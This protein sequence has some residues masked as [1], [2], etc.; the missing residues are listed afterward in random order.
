VGGLRGGGTVGKF[1][2]HFKGGEEKALTGA[3]RQA[4][5]RK[6]R[7]GERESQQRSNEKRGERTGFLG[8][9]RSYREKHKS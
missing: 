3:K 5:E 1:R 9:L 4:N 6:I 8:E 2:G 7:Q